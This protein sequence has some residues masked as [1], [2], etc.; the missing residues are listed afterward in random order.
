MFR[1]D[2]RKLA[3][4]GPTVLRLM[5]GATM[6]VHGYQKVFVKGVESFVPAVAK[7]GFPLPH[8]FAHL[9]AYSELLG[10]LALVLGLGV[11]VAAVFVGF[12]ML[13]AAF[14]VH[15]PVFSGPKSMEFP[16]NL[17]VANVALFL[18]GAGRLSLDEWL[19]SRWLG[20]R[21]EPDGEPC[22]EPAAAA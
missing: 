13:V 17:L 21:E 1:L 6:M 4:W 3:P 16:L 15:W 9:A 20:P 10:G 2:T 7:L 19:A 18:T 12:T 14:K 8:L 5:V 22:E 11:R